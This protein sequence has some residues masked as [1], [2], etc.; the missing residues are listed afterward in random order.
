MDN[1]SPTPADEL[2]GARTEAAQRRQKPA[3]T[4]TA[5]RTHTKQ[6]K[7]IA[8]LSRKEGATIASVMKATGWKKHSVYGFFAGVIRK[9]RKLDLIR[10]GDGEKA[11]YRIETGKIQASRANASVSAKSPRKAPKPARK[12][13]RKT[14]R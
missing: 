14:K 1:F 13:S 2:S 3:T 8:M 7:V 11:V 9:K 10:T 12:S 4:E 5:P 6:A